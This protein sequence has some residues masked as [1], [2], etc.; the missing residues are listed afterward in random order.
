MEL[1]RSSPSPSNIR[2]RISSK[3]K[4]NRKTYNA[5]KKANNDSHWFA[6]RRRTEDFAGLIKAINDN[7]D[8]HVSHILKLNGFDPTQNKNEAIRLAAKLGHTN[9]VY[10]LLNWRPSEYFTSSNIKLVDPTAENNE[11]LCEAVK[12]NHKDVV[13]LLLSDSRVNPSKVTCDL[14][15]SASADMKSVLLENRRVKRGGKFT[16]K[17]KRRKQE[18]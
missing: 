10:L 14:M 9:I 12:N 16:R 8:Y 18:K 15:S 5:R 17:L 3:I 13:G 4:E 6:F 7:A 2:L 11:A 1:S